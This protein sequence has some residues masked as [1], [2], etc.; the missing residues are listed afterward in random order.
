MSIYF[1]ENFFF[2]GQD[3]FF[4]LQSLLTSFYISSKR[5]G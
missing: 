3:A 4:V 5:E 1:S 2:A